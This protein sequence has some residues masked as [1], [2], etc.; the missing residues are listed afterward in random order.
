MTA[1]AGSSWH[2]KQSALLCPDKKFERKNKGRK[3]RKNLLQ[4]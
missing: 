2:I 4:I 3:S 1:I